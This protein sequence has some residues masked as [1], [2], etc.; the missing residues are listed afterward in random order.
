MS[1]SNEYRQLLEQL[2]PEHLA[3]LAAFIN[4]LL[5]QKE[6]AAERPPKR[7]RPWPLGK[8]YRRTTFK[9][10]VCNGL[11]HFTRTVY[12]DKEGRHYFKHRGE[13]TH[14][15][16]DSRGRTNAPWFNGVEYIHEGK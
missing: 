15:F 14:I 11:Q 7:E 10:D 16:T 3:D 8:E 12:E 5:I 4:C 1:N 6:A 2:S 9:V 13:M